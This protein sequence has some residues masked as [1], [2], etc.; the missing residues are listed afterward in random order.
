MKF[1]DRVQS[2]D[3]PH[4]S[5]IKTLNCCFMIDPYTSEDLPH[6]SGIKTARTVLKLDF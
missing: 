1:F 3:L 5:G 6:V 4:S 2:E